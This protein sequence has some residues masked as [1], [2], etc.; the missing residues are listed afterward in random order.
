MGIAYSRV[1][2]NASVWGA[3]RCLPPSA[4]Y[5]SEMLRTRSTRGSGPHSQDGASGAKTTKPMAVAILWTQSPPHDATP[6]PATAKVWDTFAGDYRTAAVSRRTKPLL[7]SVNGVVDRSGFEPLTS[8]VQRRR[9]P[10]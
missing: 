10:S 8:A 7:V 6:T 1:A 4:R 5:A 2:T 9:S 3:R